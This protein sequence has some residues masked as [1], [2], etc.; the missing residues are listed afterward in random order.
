MQLKIGDKIYIF[1]RSM[2]GFE[3]VIKITKT[4]ART[5]NYVFDNEISDNGYIRMKGKSKW[6]VSSGQIATEKLDQE[7]EDLKIQKWFYANKDK[8]TLEQIKQIHSLI[9][10][11][12]TN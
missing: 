11:S 7:W 5:K 1:Q 9:H 3:T 2:I 6:D 10:S 8:F 12:K 4:L